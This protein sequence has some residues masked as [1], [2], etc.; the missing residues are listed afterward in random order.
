MQ[1]LGHTLHDKD[2]P[3]GWKSPWKFAIM[4]IKLLLSWSLVVPDE[5]LGFMDPVDEKRAMEKL[6]MLPHEVRDRVT[7]TLEG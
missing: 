2:A 7:G 4:R 1:K 6:G 3:I 5:Y